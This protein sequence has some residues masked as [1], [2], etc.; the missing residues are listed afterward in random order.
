MYPQ[1]RYSLYDINYYFICIPVIPLTIEQQEF[2]CL[3]IKQI[4]AKHGCY[5]YEIKVMDDQ[6]HIL[7]TMPINQTL[8]NIINVVKSHSSFLLRKQYPELKQYPALWLKNYF[9]S[10]IG[11]RNEKTIL[12]I[13]H[14]LKKN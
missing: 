9:I 3:Q 6:T 4:L 7:F 13:I 12:R 11:A 2:L 14:R 10:T 1:N 5:I 8:K